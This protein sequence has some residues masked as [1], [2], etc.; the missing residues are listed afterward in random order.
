M[1][2]QTRTTEEITQVT[3]DE[4]R[5]FLP[6]NSSLDVGAFTVY[7]TTD[8]DTNLSMVNIRHLNATRSFRGAWA[9]A[10]VDGAQP[11]PYLEGQVVIGSDNH[12]Y[13]RSEFT[14][15][16]NPD[17]VGHTGNIWTIL[18][19]GLDEPV[20]ELTSTP[21]TIAANLFAAGSSTFEIASS[22]NSSIQ[23][24]SMETT[25]RN[26]AGTPTTG[27]VGST[28]TVNYE[29]QAN[30]DADIIVTTDARSTSFSGLHEGGQVDS[31]ITFVDAR[32]D[33]II[34]PE[35]LRVSRLSSPETAVYNIGL[36][37]DGTTIAAGTA[38]DVQW[39]ARQGTAMNAFSS[40]PTY[41]AAFPD[42]TEDITFEYQL[43][44]GTIQTGT[45]DSVTR[46]LRV[47]TPWFY[48]FSDTVP[49]D[50]SGATLALRQGETQAD[51]FST[52]NMI[53][54]ITGTVG[55]VSFLYLFVDATMTQTITIGAGIARAA[56]ERLPDVNNVTV[57]RRDG[58][59]NVAYA[60][61]RFR[62]GLA[63]SPTNFT[64]TT[65]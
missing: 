42:V 23:N 63:Q 4:N 25:T 54:P 8:P 24:P 37:P 38:Y 44:T 34:T 46:T 59:G 22:A 19:A 56:G 61:H 65:A 45:P 55:A 33:P 7:G 20:T 2:R 58:G 14:L 49:T 26:V 52:S 64:I 16:Q 62:L 39:R 36:I 50:T 11:T 57:P 27:F 10:P 48:Q 35:V 3:D 21:T 32:Q 5:F 47:Y 43:N 1:A 60:L 17:P 40:N 12:M 6:L 29:A 9:P 53:A 15:D 31:E 18:S 28:L 30:P 51:D 41:T 13:V